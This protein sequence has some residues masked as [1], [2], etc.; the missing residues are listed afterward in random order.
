MH[1]LEAQGRLHTLWLLRSTLAIS[2]APTDPQEVLWSHHGVKAQQIGVRTQPH[3]NGRVEERAGG[4]LMVFVPWGRHSP[5]PPASQHRPTT[6]E[7]CTALTRSSWV[8]LS[9]FTLNSSSSCLSFFRKSKRPWIFSWESQGRRY[10]SL[11]MFFLSPFP[12]LPILFHCFVTPRGHSLSFQ[13]HKDKQDLK[14]PF[15][16]D[17]FADSAVPT[18]THSCNPP[19][20]QQTQRDL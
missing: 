11:M 19:S 8:F 5:A 17:D 7:H 4:G 15:S 10:L 9:S 12:S 1:P 6:P 2:T 20:S 13:P 14:H 16:L 18:H 3:G